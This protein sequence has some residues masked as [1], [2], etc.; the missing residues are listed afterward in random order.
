MKK[1]LILTLLLLL[2][3]FAFSYSQEKIEGINSIETENYANRVLQ[4]YYYIPPKVLKEK[5]RVHP[6]L[7]CIPYLSGRGEEFVL[8]IFK[9]FS[10]EEG[11]V[12]VSPSF[13]FDE[14]NGK[15][16]QAISIHQH[17]QEKLSSE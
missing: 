14:K 10:E 12:I 8:P 6:L 16:K 1:Y 7:G 9:D 15:A 3:A 17:G 11:F 4:F 5:E 2:V 13:V